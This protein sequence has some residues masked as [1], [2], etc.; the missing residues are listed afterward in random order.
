MARNVSILT[1]QIRFDFENF[2]TVRER[3]SLTGRLDAQELAIPTVAFYSAKT[4]PHLRVVN[5]IG[6]HNLTRQCETS[7]RIFNHNP[8]LTQRVGMGANAQLQN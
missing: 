2:T 7:C 4:L 8:S 5:R 6:F 3:K 1:I